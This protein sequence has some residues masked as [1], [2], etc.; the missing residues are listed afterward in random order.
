MKNSITTAVDRTFIQ[1]VKLD[2]V[3]FKGDVYELVLGLSSQAT[4]SLS[5][6]RSCR[7]GR[8]YYGEGANQYANTSAFKS[9][10]KPHAD[11]HQFGLNAVSHFKNGETAQCLD[12]LEKM[13]QASSQV[14]ML[15][16]DIT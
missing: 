2:H 10:E 7:L 6:H 4:E 5:D 9:I 13:E 12:S 3:V 1:T 15:L 14:L 16:D 8:W 11:V